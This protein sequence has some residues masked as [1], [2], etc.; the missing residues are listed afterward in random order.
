MLE[1]NKVYTLSG[2]RLKV[3]N[4]QWN[5]CK[6]QFEITFD[7]NSEIHLDNDTGEI[8]QQI[9]EFTKIAALE[10]TEANKNIDVLAVVKNVGEPTSL[11]SKKSGKELHQV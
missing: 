4:M 3:A 5:T 2:G 7:Q 1:V 10:S 11:I 6:S 9:Y 8:Q